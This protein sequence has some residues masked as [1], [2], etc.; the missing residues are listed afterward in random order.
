[1]HT[2]TS[3]NYEIIAVTVSMLPDGV[4][5]DKDPQVGHRGGVPM[6]AADLA[7]RVQKPLVQGVAPEK[8]NALLQF[9]SSF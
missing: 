3:P 4:I 2:R 1:M 9:T 7:L 6:H 8:K 5:G